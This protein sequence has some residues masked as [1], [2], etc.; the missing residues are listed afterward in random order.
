MLAVCV[1]WLT[2][3][4]LG[5]KL[6]WWVNGKKELYRIRMYRMYN[7]QRTIRNRKINL[8]KSIYY[9]S[10]VCCAPMCTLPYATFLHTT[11]AC[12]S[13]SGLPL[14]LPSLPPQLCQPAIWMRTLGKVLTELFGRSAYPL[15]RVQHKGVTQALPLQQPW[16]RGMPLTTP[17]STTPL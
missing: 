11:C 3:S 1:H 8:K 15:E 14:P 12:L 17:L 10:S 5:V 13:F 6:V 9:Q 4:T 7:Y 2:S 16:G